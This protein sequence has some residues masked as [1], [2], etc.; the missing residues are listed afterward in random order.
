MASVKKTHVKTKTSHNLVKM[1]DQNRRRV[2]ISDLMEGRIQASKYIEVKDSNGKLARIDYDD[3]DG[4]PGVGQGGS[5][6]R[7]NDDKPPKDK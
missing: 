3:P 1:T 5:G 6:T 2:F 4:G 7:G